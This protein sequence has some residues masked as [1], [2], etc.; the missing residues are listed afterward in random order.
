MVCSKALDGIGTSSLKGL[1]I[2]LRNRIRLA[3]LVEG[4]QDPKSRAG[5]DPA[6]PKSTG[7]R[8]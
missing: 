3:G 8:Q 7:G 4:D 1:H 2:V 5:L 6:M